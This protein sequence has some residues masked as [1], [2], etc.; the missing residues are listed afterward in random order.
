[1]VAISASGYSAIGIKSF[2]SSAAANLAGADGGGTGSAGGAAGGVW[3]TG[4]LAPSATIAIRLAIAIT[5]RRPFRT[6]KKDEIG[7]CI[8]LIATRDC[9]TGQRRIEL[10]VLTG[11]GLRQAAGQL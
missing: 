9:P 11:N 10:S 7:R 4:A 3:V 8:L 2:S 5:P 1:M 6:S